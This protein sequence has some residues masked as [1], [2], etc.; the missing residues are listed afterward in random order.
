MSE[1]Q[2][3]ERGD[4]GIA[5]VVLAAGKGTRMKSDL[6]KVLHPLAG[7]AMIDHLLDTLAALSPGRVVVVIGPGMESVGEA[8]A[9]HACV[10]QDLQHGTGHAV[11]QA[12]AALADFAG[13]VMVLYGDTP[14]ITA[15]TLHG[16]VARRRAAD[17]PAVV[18]LGFRPADAGEYGRLVVG[19]SGG[20]EAIVEYRDADAAVR[21]IDLCNSGVMAIDGA[22]LF[23]LLDRIDNANARGEYYLTDIVAMARS[24]GRVCAAIEAAES[25]LLGVNSRSDLAQAEAVM[26]DRLRAR[27]MAEGATLIDPATTWF[28]FDTRLGRDV[29][30]GPNVVFGPGVIVGDEVQIRPFSHLEGARI[31]DRAQIGPFARLRPG[32]DVGEAARIG[33]FVEAKAA[34]VE[35]GA[36]VNHLTYI[37]DARIGAGA[38]IGA[39][40]IT[41]NY[42]GFSKH[43]TDIGA[44][45]FIGSNAALVAPVVI[46]DGAVVGAGSVISSDVPGDGLAITRAPQKILDDGAARLRRR[47]AAAKG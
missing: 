46:G 1:T 4:A 3:P 9:P 7:R 18:V 36:K 5:A 23:G 27:A 32:A 15:D 14:L 29:T 39:G 25:E 17:S 44:G 10:I 21:A 33:N 20:L 16:M 34:I 26:Q 45:A 12:R 28:S 11:A 2:R 37:G 22:A 43:T 40:T 30:V 38:N 35:A 31:A 24:D 42:D 47:L 41:C 8:V 13:D 6:P 19:D